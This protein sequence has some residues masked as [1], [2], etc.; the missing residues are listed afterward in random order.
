MIKREHFSEEHHC[1][2]LEFDLKFLHIIQVYIKIMM[3]LYIYILHTQETTKIHG[4]NN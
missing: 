4:N 3:W 1:T 2:S